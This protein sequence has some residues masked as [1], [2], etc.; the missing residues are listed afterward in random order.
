MEHS[1]LPRVL[2][3]DVDLR[4]AAETVVRQIAE[5]LRGR[6]EAAYL[7][8]SLAEGRATRDSDI[9]LLLVAETDKPFLERWRD[10]SNVLQGEYAIDLLVYTPAE[11][12]RLTTNPTVGF[13]R[14]FVTCKRRVV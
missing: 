10:F 8:G 3:P 14:S 5:R 13:W 11:F 4:D 1:I 2:R 9:D 6:V 7:F 12:E